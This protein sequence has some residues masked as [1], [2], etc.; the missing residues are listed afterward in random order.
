M[1]RHQI[2][3]AREDLHLESVIVQPLQD[4]TRIGERRID[5]RQESSQGQCG[6]IV[7]AVALFAQ[8]LVRGFSTAS[9][10]A[11]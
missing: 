11:F 3:V 8:L 2:V 1:A 6:L 9:R 5:E 7:G 10:F 4:I